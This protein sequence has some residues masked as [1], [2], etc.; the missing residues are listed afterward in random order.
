MYRGSFRIRLVAMAIVTIR[1]GP[2]RAIQRD[3]WDKVLNEGHA[4]LVRA[5]RV[6]R[7]LPSAPRCKLCNNPFGGPA[8]HVLTVDGFSP[9]R[10]N[11][12]LCSRCCDALPPGGAE[13]DV[14]VLFADIRGSRRWG[15]EVRRPTSPRCSTGSTA[16]RR[17]RCCG[18][19]R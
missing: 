3:P 16:P 17:R 10:K 9:S 13:V 6:F 1:S 8:R 14:A 19:T 18:M 15:N 7:Y 11:P 5:R 12:N 2:A 4:S